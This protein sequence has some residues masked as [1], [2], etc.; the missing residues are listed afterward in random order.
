MPSISANV[1]DDLE[2]F[3]TSDMNE[4]YS[5]ESDND[6]DVR[7]ATANN[8]DK[9]LPAPPRNFTDPNLPTRAR[10]AVSDIPTPEAQVSTKLEKD[11]SLVDEY[12]F[13]WQSKKDMPPPMN[14]ILNKATMKEYR[15]RE[16]KWLSVV[17]KMDVGTAEKDS[18]LKKLVRSGI[19]ASIRARSWQFLAR[20]RDYSKPG[21]YQSL[22][23]GAEGNIHSVIDQDV[24]R[25]FPNHIHF[26]DENGEGRKDL[27]NVLSAYA[28]YNSDLGYCQGMHCLAGCMLMQM[29]AEDAF[30]LLVATVDRYLKGYF[31]PELSQIRIDTAIIGELT[32]EHQPKLAQHLESNGVTP[33]MYIPSW[34]LTAFTLSLPWSSVLR[35]WDVFYFEGV[36]VFYRISLA[37]LEICKDHL[38][39]NCRS[40]T[41]LLTFLLHIPHKYLGPD[42]LLET[43]FRIKL[44]KTDIAKY[45]RKA[46]HMDS[47]VA[48]LPYEPGLE[49]LKVGN[50][51]SNTS[52]PSLKS[53]SGL[54][55]RIKS[56]RQPHTLPR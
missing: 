32:R 8:K 2:S 3:D 31:G 28:Q 45:A 23:Q 5:D 41:E 27:R 20:S 44:S 17:S 42:L 49:N 35:L 53:L 54:G 10:T 51:Y 18:K 21:L 36:K 7:A 12:G 6:V 48:G 4:T 30:W 22:L 40:D 26:M 56:N 38:L 50:N 16:V 46:A 1:P 19:P 13:M 14:L 55:K 47:S 24:A 25:C 33:V 29:P 34:F 52:L 9:R 39:N 43:A 15:E 11:N 37:I